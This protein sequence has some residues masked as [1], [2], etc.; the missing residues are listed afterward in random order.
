MKFLRHGIALGMVV[1][2]LAA[3]P[4]LSTQATAAPKSDPLIAK[5]KD[6]ADGSV[7]L[8]SE[9]A[10]GKVGFARTKGDLMPGVRANDAASAA[11]KVDAYLAEFAPAFGARA[12]EA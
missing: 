5:L 7:T 2:G 12:G 8:S 1:S 9:A 4:L 11:N 6:R 10:T 3:A